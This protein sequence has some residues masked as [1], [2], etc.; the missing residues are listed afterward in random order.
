MLI[1]EIISYL[2]TKRFAAT[3]EID[4][5]LQPSRLSRDQGRLKSS[6]TTVGNQPMLIMQNPRWMKV[7]EPVSFSGIKTLHTFSSYLDEKF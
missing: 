7:P 5:A 2:L 6:S 4:R 3:T 1:K